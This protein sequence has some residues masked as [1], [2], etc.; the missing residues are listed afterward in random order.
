MQDSLY[1]HTHAKS[2]FCL[3]FSNCKL[4]KGISWKVDADVEK[5]LMY[6]QMTTIQVRIC[7]SINSKEFPHS[8]R[9][10]NSATKASSHKA[11][12]WFAYRFYLSYV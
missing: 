9:N 2:H 8:L 5:T 11:A 7:I 6:Q 3:H 12:S 4:D 1:T 10:H